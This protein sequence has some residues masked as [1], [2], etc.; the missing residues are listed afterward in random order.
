MTLSLLPYDFDEVRIFDDKLSDL[1]I[2]RKIIAIENLED[3]FHMFDVGDVVRKHRLWTDKIPRVV[4]HYAVKCNPNPTVIKTLAALGASFDCASKQEIVQVMAYGVPADRIIFANPI[5]T[6]CQIRY[7]Q[8]VGVSKMTVDSM[9]ELRKIKEFYPEAKVIIRFRC[10]ALVSDAYLGAKFGCDPDEEAKLLIRGCRDLGL[11]LHGFSFHVG[12]PCGEV[13]A[14]SRGIGLCKGLIDTA[15][16]Y[17]FYNVQL[18]DIG[19]GVPGEADFVLDEFADVIN[20][21]LEDVDPSIR[22]ISEPGRYYVTSA[23]TAVAYLHGKKTTVDKNGFEH[24]MYYVNDGVY[25]SFLEELLQ[26]KSRVPQAVDESR[27]TQDKHLSTLWGPTCDSLDCILKD[28]MMPEYQLGDWLYWKDMGAYSTC[29]GT[30]F[31][32]FGVPIIFPVMRR[33]NWNDFMS[34]ISK[35]NQVIVREIDDEA[36]DHPKSDSD[37]ASELRSNNSN[38]SM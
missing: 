9:W 11:D 22:V 34:E 12:S 3:P 13:L 15:R 25:G 33:S 32:G 27:E 29:L 14:L 30:N 31:N 19:G 4:P 37:E 10:D 1:E 35:N 26:L 16:D 24:N 18:I 5:K 36:S 28:V 6:P 38:C 17:G 23:F 2:I 21:A 7:A 8:K 20:E